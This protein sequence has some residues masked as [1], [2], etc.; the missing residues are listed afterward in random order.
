MEIVATHGFPTNNISL[1]NYPTLQKTGEIVS[2]HDT[3]ILSGCISPD[4]LT[5]A[6][7]S[8][9]EN[10]KFWSLFDANKKRDSVPHDETSDTKRM[11]KLMNIR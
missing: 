3:R 7:V 2:A 6:T 9:D 10:L 4:Y 11:K 1:F 5:L 8:G